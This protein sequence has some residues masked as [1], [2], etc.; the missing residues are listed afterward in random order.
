[1]K[2][3]DI[4]GYLESL[5]PLAYQES[6]DNSGLIV[7][8]P[9]QKVKKALICLDSIEEVMDEAIRKKCDMVIAHHPIVF[10]GLKRFN[11]RTYIERVVMKAIKNNIAI[12]AIH[13]NLDN[14]TGGVNTM[15]AKKLGLENVRILA[16]KKE[17]LRKLVV[18]CPVKDAAKVRQAI[19]DAGAGVIGDYDQCS[20]NVEGTGTF[21]ASDAANPYVGEK[22]ELHH[23]EEVRIETIYPT[24]IESQLLRAMMA[25]HPY[26][27]V[28][29]DSY[30]L[31]NKHG[32]VGSGMVGELPKAKKTLSFLKELK[33]KMKADAVRYTNPVSEEVK[34][35]AICGG[36]GSFLLPQAMAAG[37]D[38][39]VTADY[40]Y[41][42]F[43]D[44]EGKI[45]IADIGH[46]ESE[47]FTIELLGDLL[48]KKFPKFAVHLTEINTNPINY[49]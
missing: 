6:Y 22:N 43:F 33:K 8:D 4:T 24:H 28:A 16:P 39:F 26:E 9:Q 19:F 45:V 40:K 44:A 48:M 25:A 18:F 10:S 42:Q 38:V 31:N 3:K 11:G 49:I 14:V 5:A 35:I 29:Y 23:E 7:G 46:Y 37:A 41:H 32:G 36:S 21:R 47:Q 20:F 30:P 34:T 12:Y 15:I 27:E 17:L 13:T 2:V 1:M